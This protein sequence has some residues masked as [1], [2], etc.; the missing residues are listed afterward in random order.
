MGFSCPFI[1]YFLL[2]R[3]EIK[4]AKLSKSYQP[5]Y[6]FM[7]F[8]CP[9]IFYFL[10]IKIPEKGYK[11]ARVGTKHNTHTHIH[12]PHTHTHTHTDPCTHTAML[13]PP[14]PLSLRPL[15]MCRQAYKKLY[16]QAVSIIAYDFLFLK[17]ISSFSCVQYLICAS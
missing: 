11:R 15:F 12:I 17:E 8:S 14:R 5:N 16:C 9:F 1:F 6:F 2:K 13:G 4:M 3:K 7:G 10:I